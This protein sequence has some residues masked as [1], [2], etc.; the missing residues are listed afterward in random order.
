MLM[1]REIQ[2]AESQVSVLSATFYSMYIDDNP[3]QTPG[4]YLALFPDDTCA[5]TTYHKPGYVVRKLQRGINSI[6]T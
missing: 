4:V 1:P 5:Y 6:K 2:A 3:P